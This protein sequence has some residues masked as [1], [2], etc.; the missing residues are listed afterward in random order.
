MSIYPSHKAV[1]V[2]IPKTG[3]SSIAALL[4]HDRLVDTKRN[5]VDP[6][7]DGRETMVELVEALGSEADDYFKFAFVRNPWD[8]FVSAYHYVAQRRPELTEVTSHKTFEDFVPAFAAD[9]ERFLSIRY[10]RPQWSYL[11]DDQGNSPADFVGRFERFDDD[12]QTILAR[13]G[14]QR[15]LMRHRKKSKRSDY[16]EYYDVWRRDAIAEIY[17]RDIEIYDYKFDDGQKRGKS[18]FLKFLRKGAS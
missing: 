5:A 9:P 4:K 10:F 8:R 16:R 15:S 13:L 2:H 17:A 12:L 11:I 1:F 18:F 6:R 14:I 7:G 3:G